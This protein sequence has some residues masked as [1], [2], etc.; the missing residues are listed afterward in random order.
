MP[1][2]AFSAH[3][4]WETDIASDAARRREAG[5]PNSVA[6]GARLRKPAVWGVYADEG[7]ARGSGFGKPGAMVLG[8]SRPRT[9]AEISA[10][11]K[12]KQRPVHHLTDLEVYFKT[13]EFVGLEAAVYREEE[14]W[15]EL[16]RVL[17]AYTSLVV[18]TIRKHKDWTTDASR[19]GRRA[20]TCKAYEAEVVKCMEEMESLKPRINAEAKAFKQ[21]A[22]PERPAVRPPPVDGGSAAP[23]GE[24]RAPEASPLETFTEAD[25]DLLSATPAQLAAAAERWDAGGASTTAREKGAQPRPRYQPRA[26]YVA[27]G[28]AH[29]ALPKG[30]EDMFPH[31]GAWGFW[32]LPGT[33]DFHVKWTGVAEILGG[34]GMASAADIVIAVKDTKM[35]LTETAIGI[36]PAQIGRYVVARTGDVKARRIMLTGHRF[37]ALEGA[38]YGLV[39]FAVD[40]MAAAESQL[41][42]L[43]AGVR[44]CAPGANAATKELLEANKHLDDVA[45]IRYAGETFAKSVK[46]DEGKEGVASFL[47]KRKPNWVQE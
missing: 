36:V 42:E 17:L 37:S 32:Y 25:W 4:S 22:P 11:V 18:E 6:L 47:E 21:A 35:A 27:A 10:A 1:R 7:R 20:E 9:T 38:D 31:E 24:A 5:I 12:A 23:G 40:D 3:R 43:V 16:F 8:G 29:F 28:A 26:E 30:F 14:N 33:P 39:D 45:M 41:A 19:H 2:D 15:Q 44:R 34:L 46:S 13:A